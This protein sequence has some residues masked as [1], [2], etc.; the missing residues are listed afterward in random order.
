MIYF[1]SEVV[2]FNFSMTK[3]QISIALTTYVLIIF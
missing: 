1:V 2:S 3:Y